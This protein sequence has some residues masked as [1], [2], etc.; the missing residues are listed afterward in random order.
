MPDSIKDNKPSNKRH[1]PSV[2]ETPPESSEGFES[3][4]RVYDFRDEKTSW[5]P[6]SPP[7]I[8]TVCTAWEEYVHPRAKQFWSTSESLHQLLAAIARGIDKMD[9]PIFGDEETC[10]IWHGEYGAD[11]LPALR[12]KKPGDA[13]GS[14]DTLNS[15]HRALVF[16]Y[17]DETSFEELK[18]V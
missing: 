17:A 18:V 16:L 2:S 14:H 5:E 11:G 8:H 7:E 3:K 9:D 12:M 10:V 6:R 13:A 4:S 1:I 15:V